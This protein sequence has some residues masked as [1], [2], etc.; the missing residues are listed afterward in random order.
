MLHGGFVKA[1]RFLGKGEDV[2]HFVHVHC[3]TDRVG[4]V[5]CK[6]FS[7]H[8]N[9]RMDSSAHLSMST[10]L[11]YYSW[12]KPHCEVVTIKGAKHSLQQKAVA[13]HHVHQW[14]QLLP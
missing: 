4:R 11:C 7:T 2:G 6:A 10:L 5:T 9:P 12:P 3:K 1:M 13:F 8:Q 14:E